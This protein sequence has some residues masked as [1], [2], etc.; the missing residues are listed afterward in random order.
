MQAS[1]C[2]QLRI[3]TTQYVDL[4]C[5]T[6]TASKP[7]RFP[8]VSENCRTASGI[9]TVLVCPDAMRVMAR[10]VERAQYESEI[11]QI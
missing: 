11:L 4:H 9:S 10:T 7:I 2:Y 3:A 5:F 6:T 1:I 8:V